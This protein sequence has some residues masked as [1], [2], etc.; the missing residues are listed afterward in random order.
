[1]SD[2]N[3]LIETLPM[4]KYPWPKGKAVR[5]IGTD[6][7][8][9]AALFLYEDRQGVMQPTIGRGARYRCDDG[10]LR[11]TIRI[12]DP[13]NGAWREP[14]FFRGFQLIGSAKCK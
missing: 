7:F 4:S 3:L 9:P 6:Y 10:T 2:L 5:T 11:S 1:M 8:G 12:N 14:K 13:Q